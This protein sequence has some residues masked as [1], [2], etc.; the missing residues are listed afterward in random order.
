MKKTS[1]IYGTILLALINFIVRTMGFVYRIILSRMI[2]SQAIGLYQMIFPFLMVL[3]T[4]PT[5]G[6]PIAVSKLVAGEN[7]LHNRKGVYRVLSLS[8]LLGGLL[9]GILTA[10]VSFNME[11]ITNKILKNQDL[12]YPLLWTIPAIGL[13]SFS[14]ILRGFFYG[15]KDIKPPAMAQILEQISRI[16]FVIALLYYIKPKH[17]V[18]AATIAIMGLTVGEFFGLLYLVLRFN[19]KKLSQ[20]RGKSL[21]RSD[22]F[23]R[24][25]NSILYISVPITV[26]RLLSVM[27]QTVNSILIPQRLEASG[28]TATAAIDTFGKISG[29]AMPL[30]FLPFTV[31]TA[32]VVNIIPN[33]S[34]EL[35]INNHREI[36]NKTSLALRITLLTAIP[37]TGIYMVFGGDMATI[38]FKDPEVGR[39][40][41]LISYAT[42]FLCMQNTLSGILH[43][44]GKQISTTINFMLGMLIQLYCT[45]FL[46]A[47]PKYGIY[48]FII[49]FILSALVTFILHSIVLLRHVKIKLSLLENIIKPLLCTLLMLGIIFASLAW[50]APH[51]SL[52][53]V[54]AFPLG[55]L[56]YVVGLIVTR[57]IDIGPFIHSIRK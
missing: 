37:V 55:M 19:F 22:S 31:T 10:L 30:L 23:F 42:L 21:P 49:G 46:V 56:G 20:Y 33:I 5:A 6:I 11:F 13:I 16:S 28:L 41:S 53:K 14:S 3:I 57:A 50:L 51:G 40:L 4:L 54:I 9:A 47:N 1:F 43:G 8:L 32:L 34:E 38:I 45:Y 36:S 18:T 17:P 25:V 27:M 39:Y 29:M 44:M 52:F 2:G 26:S 7:S 15:L 48:G 35:A 24:T 12:Y